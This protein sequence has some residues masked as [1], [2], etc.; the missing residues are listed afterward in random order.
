MAEHY[1]PKC[2][3]DKL[4]NAGKRTE[5]GKQR[6]QC[7]SCGFRTTTPLSDP[8]ESKAPVSIELP[9]SR[10][11][12]ITAAQ[13][14][15]APHKKFLQSLQQYAKANDAALLVVPFRYHN[16]ALAWSAGNKREDWWAEELHPYLFMQRAELNA[17]LTVLADIKIRP[18]AT[19]PLSGFDSI[20]G[21]KSG[22]IAHPKVE[23]R[24]IPTPH[25]RLPK[26]MATTGA[27][28][29]K[30]YTDS[31]T[32]KKGEFHHT[33]GAAVVELD[34]DDTFHL[35][36]IIALS[37][38]TFIDLDKRYAPE[39]VTQAPPAEALILGDTH[40]DFNDPD[41]DK[42]TFGD[43]GIVATLQP[44]TLVWHD[45]LDFFS[46]SHHHRHL[47]FVGV[48]K[49]R[50]GM[51]NVAAEVKRACE[52]VD[53]RSPKGTRNVLVPSNHPEAMYRWLNETDWRY[54]PENAELYLETALA[55]VRSAKMTPNGTDV[56]DPFLLWARRLM[57]TVS[58]TTYLRRGESFTVKGIEVGL[59]G[60]IGPHGSRGSARSMSRIGVKSIIGHS[61]SPAIVEGCYQVGTSSRLQ[62]EYNRA[63]PSAWLH[64]H[65]VVYA[66]SKRS[67]INVVGGKWRV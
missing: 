13:N 35:R 54:D 33:Y 62:L 59:H 44:K 15:T 10:R 27:V 14:A 41:A 65:C 2:G 45:L 57:K 1:C 3:H 43:K 36:Q 48:A 50:S 30:N 67:L 31:K 17:N 8:S 4:Y 16:S 63:S 6:Y 12:L 9:K 37:D 19:T 22:I 56:D 25:H 51:T 34:K 52:F 55:L 5:T 58:R 64:T 46:H 42:A 32:G 40:A 53:K 11:Y 60:D 61:H 23:L 49:H 66:N 24:A 29:K 7:A 39:G 26:I 18:T 38:G 47:P 28:T 20:T 21:A